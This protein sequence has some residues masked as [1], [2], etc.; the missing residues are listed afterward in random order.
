VADQFSRE[1]LPIRD[2]PYDEPLPLDAKDGVA[3]LPPTTGP[4]VP[5]QWVAA[6]PDGSTILANGASGAGRAFIHS[7]LAG[8]LRLDSVDP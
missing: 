6:P 5:D 8:Y 3:T 7:Y 1:V 4:P 2:R